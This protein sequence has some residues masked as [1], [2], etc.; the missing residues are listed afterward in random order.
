[1]DDLTVLLKMSFDQ[2]VVWTQAAGDS[3]KC[4]HS[5]QYNS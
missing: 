4:K 2:S 5:G 3:V 1:M